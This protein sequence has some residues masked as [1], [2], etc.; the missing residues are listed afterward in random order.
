MQSGK[1]ARQN[2]YTQESIEALKKTIE[3]AKT[4]AE[5]ERATEEEVAAQTVAL[6][7]A[8]DE[9]SMLESAYVTYAMAVTR[10]PDKLEYEIGESF[11][12][13]GMEVT[14]YEKA[15]C[16]NAAG[17]KSVEV[18]YSWEDRDGAVTEFTDLFAVTVGEALEEEYCTLTIKLER[19]PNK[20]DYEI[21]NE[22]DPSGTKKVTVTYRGENKDGEEEAFTASFTVKVTEVW[23]AYYTTGIQVKKKPDKTAYKTGEEFDPTGMKVAAIERASVSN[24]ARRERVLTE[25]EYEVEVPSFETAGTKTIRIV[26]E[27]ADKNGRDKVFRDSF[28]V[29]VTAG[30]SSN[31]GSGGGSM[32]CSEWYLYKD[33]WYYFGEDGDMFTAKITPD[34]YAVDGKGHWIS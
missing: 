23:E 30:S 24:A 14:A 2:G 26:Y 17:S 7:K 5:D 29:K 15:S 28:T 13:A 3:K 9:M 10:K 33:F 11:D 16:S 6:K 34:G 18:S 31:G 22:F 27:A 12:P 1:R 19:K 25:G 21:G 4:T 32:K 20:T 8:M